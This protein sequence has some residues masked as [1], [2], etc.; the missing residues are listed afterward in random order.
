M[1][2]DGGPF[3]Q[4]RQEVSTM[5][6]KIQPLVSLFASY[7]L[8]INDF[9]R[10]DRGDSDIAITEASDSAR[11]VVK[12]AEAVTRNSMELLGFISDLPKHLIQSINGTK[13]GSFLLC[14]E[15]I[16]SFNAMGLSLKK[17][18]TLLKA[19]TVAAGDRL[20]TSATNFLQR[21]RQLITLQV[22]GAEE[23]ASLLDTLQE[24]FSEPK[25][26]AE[27]PVPEF[28]REVELSLAGIIA[29]IHPSVKMGDQ[30]VIEAMTVACEFLSEM[31]VQ[32]RYQADESFGLTNPRQLN[33]EG[34]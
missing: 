17:T 9:P 23:M 27:R 21:I 28:I 16:N 19:V 12:L 6:Y 34:N 3:L 18:V 31:G 29:K 26:M 20:T 24:R 7:N 5:K 4:I 10:G 13:P 30:M 8:D 15:I 2:R 32:L 14:I 11:D 22:Q 33:Q 1:V 25:A